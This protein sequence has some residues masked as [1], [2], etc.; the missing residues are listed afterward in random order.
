MS[1]APLQSTPV[2]VPVYAAGAGIPAPALK[3]AQEAD[4]MRFEDEVANVRFTSPDERALLEFGPETVRYYHDR[5]ALWL[6]E[7]RPG[8]GLAG[9]WAASFGSETPAEAI[10]AFTRAVACMP[11]I[12]GTFP[13]YGAGPGRPETVFALVQGAGWRESRSGQRIVHI[14]PDGAARLVL[15]EAPPVIEGQFLAVGPHWHASYREVGGERDWTA[16]FTAEVPAEAVAAFAA[17]LCDPAGLDPD[18]DV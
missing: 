9:A 10:A 18:R 15:D 5:D 12:R 8:P 14:S 7:Y 1:P 3:V 17:V 11:G 4:W 6:A 13:G 16:Q 2:L